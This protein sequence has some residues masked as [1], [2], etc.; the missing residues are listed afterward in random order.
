MNQPKL[1]DK[2]EIEIIDKTNLILTAFHYNNNSN[3]DNDDDD[4]C[5]FV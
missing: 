5:D 1:L 2:L 3:N 4:E